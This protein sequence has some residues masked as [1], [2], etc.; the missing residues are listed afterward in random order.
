MPHYRTMYGVAV[1]LLGD[2]DGA[3]DAVQ[4][5]IVRLWEIRQEL[6]DVRNI[7]GFVMKVTRNICLDAIRRI[8]ISADI[9]DP[10]VEA[11]V[12]HM[13][14]NDP[15][16]DKD[17]LRHVEHLMAALPESQRKVLM[18][19]AYADLDNDEIAAQLGITNETVRQQ[20]SRARRTLRKLYN[21]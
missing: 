4:D 8:R 16:A 14:L 17:S 11:S 9:S 21:C 5:T 1:A 3:S 20:L 15:I 12:E 2:S 19:R 13:N 6:Y 10:V 18:L 7:R